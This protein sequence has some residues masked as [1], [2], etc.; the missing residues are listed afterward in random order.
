MILF[1]K[2]QKKN[3]SN[4]AQKKLQ[5]FVVLFLQKF[6]VICGKV[7]LTYASRFF[8]LHFELQYCVRVMCAVI[9]CVFYASC[10]SFTVTAI[11]CSYR[12]AFMR[13]TRIQTNTH[14]TH[15]SLYVFGYFDVCTIFHI[16]FLRRRYKLFFFLLCSVLEFNK[17]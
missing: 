3:E 17:F 14:P 4:S 2:F 13:C 8:L 11:M 16:C 6:D 7:S 15:S 9:F 5:F 1:T 12:D 10:F